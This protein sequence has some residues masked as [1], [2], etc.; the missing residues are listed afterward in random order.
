VGKEFSHWV[1]DRIVKR[2]PRWV[3]KFLG[4]SR[5][6]GNYVDP[7]RHYKHDPFRYP[8]GWRELGNRYHPLLQQLDR[9]PRTI[10]GTAAGTAWGAAGEDEDGVCR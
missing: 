3:K 6:N 10:Y 9:V 1:P 2:G 5:L 8:K 4:R 7:A